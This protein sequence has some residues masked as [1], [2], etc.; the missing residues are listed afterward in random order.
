MCIWKG[1]SANA[2]YGS[3]RGLR[4]QALARKK[5]Q[6]DQSDALSAAEPTHLRAATLVAPWYDLQPGHNTS[7]PSTEL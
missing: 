2:F 5:R 4:Q 7:G 3:L 1:A 6:A